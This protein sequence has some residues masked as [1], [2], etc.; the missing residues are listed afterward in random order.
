M[1]SRSQTSSRLIPISESQ[2]VEVILVKLA[3]GRIVA[4]TRAEL[5][6]D[7]KPPTVEPK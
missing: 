6:H 2:E 5:A 1:S 4:R 7:P 3:D